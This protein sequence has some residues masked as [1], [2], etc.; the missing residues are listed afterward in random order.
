MGMGW[1]RIYIR[2]TCEVVGVGGD[3]SIR[4]PCIPGMTISPCAFDNMGVLLFAVPAMGWIRSGFGRTPGWTAYKSCT[5]L[6]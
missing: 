6:T 4:A 1:G 3:C 2:S 5:S